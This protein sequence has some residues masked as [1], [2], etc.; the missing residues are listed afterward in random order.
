M[1]TSIE[2]Q[3][4]IS[5]AQEIVDIHAVLVRYVNV[6]ALGMA[7]GY[8]VGHALNR[9]GKIATDAEYR[10]K[11]RQDK[12]PETPPEAPDAPL[13]WED[14]EGDVHNPTCPLPRAPGEDDCEACQ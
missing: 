2:P 3:R 10:I 5:V 12:T 8:A 1:K 6:E 14:A 7:E 13:S 9:L 11:N 4:R